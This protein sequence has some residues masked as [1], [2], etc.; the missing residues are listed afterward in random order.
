MKN[1]LK[2]ALRGLKTTPA[3]V[4]LSVVGAILIL[5]LPVVLV[6]ILS[7]AEAEREYQAR[8]AELEAAGFPVGWEG[9]ANLY[10]ELPSDEN[11][12]LVYQEAFLHIEIPPEVADTVPPWGEGSWP[13]P[14]EPFPGEWTPLAEELMEKN[15]RGIEL[16]HQAATLP[17]ARFPIDFSEGWDLLIPHVSELRTSA[18]LLSFTAVWQAKDGHWPEAVSDLDAL[19]ALADALRDEPSLISQLTRI[20]ILGIGL[21]ALEQALSYSFPPAELLTSLQA[22]I[23]RQI[24]ENSIYEKALTGELAITVTSLDDLRSDPEFR[25]DFGHSYVSGTPWRVWSYWYAGGLARDKTLY[26]NLA[27]RNIE[28]ARVPLPERLDCIVTDE[29]LERMFAKYK[30]PSENLSAVLIP[31]VSRLFEGEARILSRTQCAVIALA[32]ERYRYDHGQLPASLEALVPA[33]LNELP[34]DPLTGDA[35]DFKEDEPW[36]IVTSPSVIPNRLGPPRFQLPA[37]R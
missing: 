10:G 11:A 27:V 17:G 9:V 16:L 13:E 7:R 18:R 4:G 22:L 24:W 3:I 36:R 6:S 2:G 5:V 20:A 33:Y 25:E 1:A 14:G 15:A 37:A 21:N 32:A 8:L 12:A 35:F 29:D 19:F 30:L 26:V 31:T 23:H 34:P 28:A